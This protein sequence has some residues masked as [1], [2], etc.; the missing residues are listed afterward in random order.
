MEK[1]IP[2]HL[3]AIVEGLF[4]SLNMFG[5]DLENTLMVT[6]KFQNKIFYFLRHMPIEGTMITKVLG[7]MANQ[8]SAV[9]MF[10]FE[11]CYLHNMTLGAGVIL[12]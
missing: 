9:D 2:M 6:K 11:H 12:F 3:E 1:H 4:H 7:A 10:S 8:T 5:H